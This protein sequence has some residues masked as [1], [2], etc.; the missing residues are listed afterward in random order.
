MTERELAHEVYRLLEAR[1]E[2]AWHH[3]PDVRRC[4]GHKGF[5]D[6]VVIGVSRIAFR[7]LKG[8]DTRTRRHQ[9]EFGDAI[10]STAASWG[11]WR[12]SD[13]ESGRIARE[14]DALGS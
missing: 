2:L 9:A 13:L 5:P 10:M 1:P 8:T 14:L 3:C 11:V 4:H 12:P 7:E 6:L